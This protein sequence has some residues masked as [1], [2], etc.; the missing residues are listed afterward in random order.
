MPETT[1]HKD[2][3]AGFEENKIWFYVKGRDGPPGRPLIIGR[4]ALLRRLVFLAARQHGPT[5]NFEM[6]PP[7]GDFVSTQ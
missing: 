7:A 1:V 2:C 5:T 4:A 6:P 3:R